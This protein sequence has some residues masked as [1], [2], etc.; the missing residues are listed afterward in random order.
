MRLRIMFIAAVLWCAIC[1][2]TTRAAPSATGPAATRFV[3][4][5]GPTG[6]WLGTLQAGGMKL[7]IVFHLT[8]AAN[9]TISGT[10]DSIDQ[11]VKG[12]ALSKVTVSGKTVRLEC[13]S[14][15]GVFAGKLSDG[16]EKMEGTWQQ[17]GASMPL[18]LKRTNEI[19]VVVRPQDPKPPLPYKSEDVSYEDQKAGVTL[20]GTLT[21]PRGSGPFAA[22]ILVAGSGPN[23]RN[24]EVFNHRPFLVLA[25]ALTR[26]GI[27]VLRYDKRGIGK[28]TGDFSKATLRDFAD[29]ARAG[30]RY[31]Q[32]RSDINRHRIGLLG[33][34]EGGATV[35]LVAAGSPDVSFVVLL[36]APGVPLDQ[37]LAVQQSAIL[38]AI[39]ADQATLTAAHDAQ[40]KMFQVVRT[41]KDDDAA[42]KQLVPLGEQSIAH[43]PEPV[44]KTLAA[45]GQ[46][47]LRMLLSPWFRQLLEIDPA[48]ALSKLRCP[49]LA[50]DGE[51]DLQVDAKQ[52]LPAIEAAL[53]SAPTRDV[54]IRPLPG[55]NH[56]FQPAE[57]GSPTEYGT[58]ETTISPDALKL[59]GDWIVAHTGR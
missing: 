49:V 39:G 12:I 5:A 9:G 24:E 4:P 58:I 20:A 37:L 8:P 25:D 14:I 43:L 11:G 51:K 41:E 7:R 21:I 15:A 55:L 44:R 46:A 30:I 27:A 18:V 35:P 19:P 10:L 45:S 33:H 23:N 53:K 13:P 36:A 28:S 48:D 2:V 6:D 17:G 1:P 40:Q 3:H 57:T 50:I 22:V 59:I 56:L 34:S 38:K 26:R 42:M 16:D 32:S 47:Q 52:N 31:L 29:D 54:T